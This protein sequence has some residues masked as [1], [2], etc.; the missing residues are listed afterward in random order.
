MGQDAGLS[1][2]EFVE[3]VTDYLERRLDPVEQARFDR[4][5][6]DCEGCAIYLDQIRQAIRVT[7]M[8]TGEQL[9][10]EACDELLAAFRGWR[11]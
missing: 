6:A 11:G 7:G 9:S 4:H 1:C 3:V 5:L 10:K 8:L 2:R